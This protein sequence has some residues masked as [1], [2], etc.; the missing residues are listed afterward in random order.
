VI[1]GSLDLG[2]LGANREI[3]VPGKCEIGIFGE[4]YLGLCLLHKKGLDK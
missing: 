1:G 4:I 3:G 2:L